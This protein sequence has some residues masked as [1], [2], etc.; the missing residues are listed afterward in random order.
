VQRKI[1]V[2]VLSWNRLKDTLDCLDSIQAQR[3]VEATVWV[4]DQGSSVDCL[5]SLR[6]RCQESNIHLIEPGRNLGVPGGRNLGMRAG[7]A[8]VIVCLDNDA[9]FSHSDVLAKTFDG[10]MKRPE[11]GVLAFAIRDGSGLK[12]DLG[13]WVFPQPVEDFFETPF[14]TARFCGAGHAVRRQA[15]QQ[16]KGYDEQLFF[17]AEELDLAYQIIGHGYTLRYEPELGVNHRSSLEGR[18]GWKDGRFRYNVRNMLYLNYKYFRDPIQLVYYAGGY[19]VKGALNRQFRTAL[20]GIRQSIPLL[21]RCRNVEPLSPEAKEYI[22]RHEFE[23]RGSAL[24]RFTGEVLVF[25]KETLT[26]PRR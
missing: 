10:F 9:V 2:V 24:Q 18:M 16:T 23:P 6:T 12:P 11:L 7:H 22:M 19:L 25:M 1:D 26:A 14:P 4:V 15:L 20:L 17:F 21:R 8:P 3:G 13:N 5:E